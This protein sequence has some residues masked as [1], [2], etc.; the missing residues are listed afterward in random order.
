MIGIVAGWIL[1][2][3]VED[4]G[5]LG[6]SA[7]RGVHYKGS[8][9]KRHTGEPAGGDRDLLTVEDVGPEIDVASLESSHGIVVAPRRVTGEGDRVLGDEVAG[10][11]P[12]LVTE[13]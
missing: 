13:G 1:G 9:T 2:V 3:P 4:P 6:S 11:G 5:V 8:L 7:L 10:I 12:D